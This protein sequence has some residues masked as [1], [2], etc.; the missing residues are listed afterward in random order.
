MNKIEEDIQIREAIINVVA[1]FD[2]FDYPVS[3]FELW[4]YNSIKCD[5][6]EIQEI[7]EDKGN[8]KSLIL[9]SKNGF[10]F[11]KGR[12]NIVNTRMKR[13]NS[14]DRKFKRAIKVSKIFKLIP[15]IKM[16]A[17]SNIIGSN[18]LKDN[19]DIDFFIITENRR[20]WITRFF[21]VGITKILGL[22]PKG[23]KKRDKICLSFYISEDAIDFKKFVLDNKSTIEKDIF[24]IYY[25]PALIPIYGGGNV[26]KKLI[27][28]NN[29]DNGFL[30][31][32]KPLKI[33]KRRSISNRNFLVYRDLIDLFIGG[34]EGNFKK[35][36]LK[37][38]P[39][40][41]KN[42][43]NKDTRVIITD[44]ILKLHVNDRRK[45]Y[46]DRYNKKINEIFK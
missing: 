38:M 32:W 25:L 21:C 33:V 27:N 17:I 44:Q 16:I 5:L 31:N 3:V 8:M 14:T 24:F 10:Y 36:Q 34:L 42:I 12:E 20:I 11:L 9:D 23:G 15:W 6:V 19:S 37:L 18:N 1:F 4:Q 13:Y 2:M 26:Y 28:A 29:L 35:L 41:L 40:S 22:R 43:M 45:E 46:R 39:E 30:P 7:L